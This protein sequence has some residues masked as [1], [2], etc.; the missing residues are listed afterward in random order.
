MEPTQP[1]TNGDSNTTGNMGEVQEVQ[2]VLNEWSIEPK[3][4]TVN[5]GKV[6]FVVTNKGQFE[7]NAV[8]F[9]EKDGEEIA[10]TPNFESAEGAQSIEV[11]LEPGTYKM[12]CDIIGHEQQGMV[13]TLTVK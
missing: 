2:L 13:G 7:H 8:F 3:N 11:D 4:P 1:A 9:L 6:K 12:V 5:A 10:R